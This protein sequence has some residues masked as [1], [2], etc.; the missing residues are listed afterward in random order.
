M[1]LTF[2]YGI[3]ENYSKVMNN[4]FSLPHHGLRVDALKFS[5]ASIY[6]RFNT[7]ASAAS[8]HNKIQLGFHVI[9]CHFHFIAQT[10]KTYY[11]EAFV[12][13]NI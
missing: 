8:K 2:K 1:D 7:C 4:L 5:W 3:F 9:L 11:S 6:T 13:L 12:I 10:R